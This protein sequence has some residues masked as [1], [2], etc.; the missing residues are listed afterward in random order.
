MRGAGRRTRCAAGKS[1]DAKTS[2]LQP[3]PTPAFPWPARYVQIACLCPPHASAS[4][5]CQC[6]CTK[7]SLLQLPAAP[8]HRFLA[9]PQPTQRVQI[10]CLPR[11][12]LGQVILSCVGCGYCQTPS[13]PIFCCLLCWPHPAPSLGLILGVGL[14][15]KET[16]YLGSNLDLLTLL[17]VHLECPCCKDF[18]GI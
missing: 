3:L 9:F 12:L 18:L 11:L 5:Y 8:A 4:V 13:A 6:R 14:I 17:L 15:F 16:R 1:R 7:T 10:A 2:L